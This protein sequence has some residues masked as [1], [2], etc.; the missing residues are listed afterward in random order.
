MNKWD[1]SLALMPSSITDENKQLKQHFHPLE[2]GGGG[3]MIWVCFAATGP[4]QTAVSRGTVNS[5]LYSKENCKDK[6]W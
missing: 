6:P 3:M 2:H 5:S 4:E 1:Q